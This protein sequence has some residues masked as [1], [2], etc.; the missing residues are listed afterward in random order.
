M[1]KREADIF[2]VKIRTICESLD[3]NPHSDEIIMKQILDRVV[4]DA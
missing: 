1:N 2:K 3:V 4:I